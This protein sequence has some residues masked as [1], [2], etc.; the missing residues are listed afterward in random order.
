[1]I[2]TQSASLRSLIYLY[3]LRRPPLL[4]SEGQPRTPRWRRVLLVLALAG[5]LAVAH[6]CHGEDV[7][8]ELFGRGW[9]TSLT[10]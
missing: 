4:A 9:W 3:S 1:M 6:G 2:Q 8:D 5:L 10:K 7:D